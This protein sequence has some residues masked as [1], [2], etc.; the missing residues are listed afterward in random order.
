MNVT[1]KNIKLE[2]LLIIL[3]GIIF[4]WSILFATPQ[5]HIGYWGQVEGMIVFSHFFSAIAALLI[6]KIGIY[7]QEIRKYFAHP[8]V[9]I[10]LLI[11]LY[12]ILSGLFQMLPVLAFYGSPQLGQGAFGYFSLS[13][14]TVLYLYLLNFNKL[15]F[16]L[17]INL[18]FITLFIT[19]GSFY[20]VITGIV[21][22]FWF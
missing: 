12:S 16:I 3:V 15:K 7:N 14:L 4:P 17:L 8:I 13:L 10:P 2:R 18:F 1:I 19:I 9:Y 5:L 22:S 6:L 11:G 20:P 21:I